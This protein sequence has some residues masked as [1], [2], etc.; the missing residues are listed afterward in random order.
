MQKKDTPVVIGA[1]RIGGALHARSG[2]PL[3]GRPEHPGHPVQGDDTAVLEQPPGAPILICVR[4]DDLDAVLRR[5]P[6]ARRPDLVF[7]Q[8][9]MLEDFLA[10]RGLADATRGLLFLSVASRG[11]PIEVGGTSPF[12]GPHAEHMARLFQGIDLAAEAIDRARFTAVMLEKLL[13]NCV[14]GLLCQ[15]HGCDVGTV[16]DEYAG[17]H[18]GELE[19]LVAELAAVGRAALGVQVGD[20]EL[21]ERLGAYS[22]SIPRVRAAVREWRWR[23]GWF[24]R[25]AAR[26]GLPLPLHARLTARLSPPPA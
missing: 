25:T 22:R 24:V 11:A 1:G 9:G 6:E 2:W 17:E 20:A 14:F 10:E 3:I 26:L 23:N 13:W 5:V 8:N 18:S 12:T 16:L 4:N 21:V 7:I 15:V 19:T